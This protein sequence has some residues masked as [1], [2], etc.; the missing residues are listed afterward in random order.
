MVSKLETVRSIQCHVGHHEALQNFFV[1]NTWELDIN[2]TELADAFVMCGV[3]YG[4]ES[5]TD[6][7]SY[8]SYAFDLYR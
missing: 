1:V 8:I 4:L 5:S 3:L 2:G 6:R 7:D